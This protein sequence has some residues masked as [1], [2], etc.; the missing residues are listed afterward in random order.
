MGWRCL[1]F[2]LIFPHF[3]CQPHVDTSPQTLKTFSFYSVSSDA[4]C[5]GSSPMEDTVSILADVSFFCPFLW[6]SAPVFPANR[7]LPD[8]RGRVS[9]FGLCWGQWLHQCSERAGHAHGGGLWDYESSVCDPGVHSCVLLP[10][11]GPDPPALQR[12]SQKP[13]LQWRRLRGHPAWL[14]VRKCWVT[15][16]GF[17]LHQTC[18][19]NKRSFPF[20]LVSSPQWRLSPSEPSG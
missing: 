18:S 13:L 19:F 2:S 1:D 11:T 9:Q 8:P 4:S 10:W 15:S 7:R 16:Y 17:C 12:L 14:Q 20:G 3:G 6:P 5:E